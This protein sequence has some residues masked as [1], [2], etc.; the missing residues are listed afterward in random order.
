MKPLVYFVES[1][2]DKEVIVYKEKL[3]EILK[4]VYQAGFE[5]GERSK[6]DLIYLQHD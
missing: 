4:E 2:N 1:V 3:Q 5:D 6:S